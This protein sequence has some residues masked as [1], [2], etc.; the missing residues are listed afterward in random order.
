MRHAVVQRF[1]S[2]PPR[3]HHSSALLDEEERFLKP[4][5]VQRVQERPVGEV[6]IGMVRILLVEGLRYLSGPYRAVDY[7]RHRWN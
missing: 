5:L 4:H 2:R 7:R 6:L 1:R 3:R